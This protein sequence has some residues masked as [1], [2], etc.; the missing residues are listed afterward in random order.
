MRRVAVPL[1]VI[2]AVIAGGAYFVLRGSP[3]M[4][5]L[6]LLARA[7]K[8]ESGM[9]VKTELNNDALRVTLSTSAFPKDAVANE[10]V[11]KRTANFVRTRLPGA[12]SLKSIEVSLREQRSQGAF[13]ITRSAGTFVWTPAQLRDN[14]RA[15]SP[16]NPVASSGTSNVTPAGTPA[17][18]VLR[19]APA[20]GRAAPAAHVRLASADPAVRWVKDSA[21]VADFD[22]DQVA[23]T[24]VI[25]RRR[26]E[27]HLGLAR[28]ADPTP[29]ILIFDVGP[30]VKGSVCGARANATVESL[31]FEPA[32]KGLGNLEGFQRSSTCKGVGLGDGDCT[33]VHIFFSGKTQ[34]L[35]WYQR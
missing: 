25:G 31:D 19:S 14:A 8:E 23:D 15:A 26:G 12:D 18:P 34:H 32:E 33:P 4:K 28:T 13:R 22:C 24:V 29:Q 16:T 1:L 17:K 2:V 7:L 11:A 20:P 3:N 21:L 27:I 5:D 9:S 35:E 30:G 6:F 10:R